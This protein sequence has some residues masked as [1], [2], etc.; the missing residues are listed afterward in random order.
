M[1]DWYGVVAKRHTRNMVL[2]K[3]Y[4]LQQM[5]NYG[6]ELIEIEL[7]DIELFDIQ[8]LDIELFD[9]QLLDI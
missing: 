6:I 9:I 4:C 5:L 7:Y 3:M 2:K 1:Q 8:L